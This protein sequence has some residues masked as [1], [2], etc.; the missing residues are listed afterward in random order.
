MILGMG[1]GGGGDGINCSVDNQ[2]LVPPGSSGSQHRPRGSV[3]FLP[4][5]NEAGVLDPI[6]LFEGYGVWATSYV[7]RHSGLRQS[8]QDLKECKGWELSASRCA[9]KC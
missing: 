9:L 4:R 5:G 3:L 2:S 1:A 8:E 6:V 7:A